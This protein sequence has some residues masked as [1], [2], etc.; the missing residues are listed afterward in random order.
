MY[1]ANKT[2]LNFLARCAKWRQCKRVSECIFMFVGYLWVCVF[3]FLISALIK[4]YEQI[5]I[6]NKS[7]E[8]FVSWFMSVDQLL[9]ATK[10]WAGVWW[11]HTISDNSTLQGWVWLEESVGRLRQRATKTI[12]VKS[13]VKRIV[14]FG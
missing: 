6:S 7:N 1:L 8:L 14:T 2:V 13:N 12:A 10:L 3:I 5:M 4:I 9:I 11:T